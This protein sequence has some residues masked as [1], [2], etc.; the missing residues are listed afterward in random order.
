MSQ[1][2]QVVLSTHLTSA[3][4][5]AELRLSIYKD[6]LG[7]CHHAICRRLLGAVSELRR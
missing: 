1:Q 6:V 3:L 5:V 4:R 7:L 2:L